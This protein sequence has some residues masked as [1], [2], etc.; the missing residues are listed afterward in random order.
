MIRFFKRD[1]NIEILSPATGKIVPIEEVPD[2]TF[3]KKIAGDGLAIELTDGKI[4]AP[5]DGEITSVYNANHCLVV[6]SESGL[7][8]L[9]HIGIDTVKLK[10]EGFKRYVELND[11][12][13]SGDLLLEADLNLLKSKGKSI[14]T[15][16][17]ITNRR[18]IESIEKMDGEVEKDKDLLM[19]VKMKND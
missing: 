12:V 2:D 18:N 1:K 9:I 19:K 17:V 14:L 4:V 6:R 7:E 13:K 5:F 15:P 3:S 10:G 16:V 11:K 8:L